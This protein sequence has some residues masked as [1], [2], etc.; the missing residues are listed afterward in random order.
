MKVLVICSGNICRSPMA[1]EY[2][3]ARAAQSGLAHLVVDSAGT[4]GIEGRP[5]S[6]EAVAVMAEAGYDLSAHRSRG[7]AYTDLRSSDLVIGMSSGH[8][9]HLAESYP[10][11]RDER[12]LLRAFEKSPQPSRSAPDLEDPITRPIEF[13]RE[14]F[15]RIRRCVDHLTIH[16]KHG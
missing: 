4:L 1:A 16:L 13:Y 2:L 6:A 8:L 12:L 11:G 14:T 9:E 15:E 5:A 3:R 7:L 10:D